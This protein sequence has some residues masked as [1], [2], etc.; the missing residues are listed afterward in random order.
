VIPSFADAPWCFRARMGMPSGCHKE[1]WT[2]WPRSLHTSK[3]VI[4]FAMSQGTPQVS[5]LRRWHETKF[6]DPRS[7]G[8]F[9]DNAQDLVPRPPPTEKQLLRRWA[10]MVKDAHAVGLTSVHDAGF[11][12]ISLKFFERLAFYVISAYPVRVLICSQTSYEQQPTGTFSH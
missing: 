1:F 6:P 10:I 9:L 8:V 3:A 12:P 2:P 4:S 11:S 5:A 7:P